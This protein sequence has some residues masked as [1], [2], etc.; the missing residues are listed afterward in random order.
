MR[1]RGDDVPPGDALGSAARDSSG[2]DAPDDDSAAFREAVRDV[3]PLPAPPRVTERPRPPPVAQFR[4]ADD[5]AVL[6]ESLE[7]GPG[8]LL[9]ET[10]DELL[11]RR[12]IVSGRTLRRLQ[13]G[14]FRVEDEIDL[15]GLVAVEAREALRA[16]LNDSLKRGLRCVRVIHGKGLRSGPRGP[17]LK[18]AVNTW[19]RKTGAVLAF[20]SARQVDGGTGAVYVLLAH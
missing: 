4:R 17:V 10:G 13:R 3:R 9:V 20:A 16:F 8:E 6:A 11:F 19:L 12:A 7:L 14:E 2:R 15:H 5:E 1:P 18:H